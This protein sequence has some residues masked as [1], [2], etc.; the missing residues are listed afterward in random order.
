MPA[1]RLGVVHQ[2]QGADGHL[3]RMQ[4]QDAERSSEKQEVM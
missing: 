1:V 2:E 4:L 3:R